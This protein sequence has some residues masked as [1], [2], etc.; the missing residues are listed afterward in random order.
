MLC[1]KNSFTV[2]KQNQ[3][4]VPKFTGKGQVCQ[5]CFPL[6]FTRGSVLVEARTLSVL[7]GEL[8]K[9]LIDG[10]SPRRFSKTC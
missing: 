1:T 8:L 9:H 2:I 10:C 4:C 7:G 6:P 5:G 3:E